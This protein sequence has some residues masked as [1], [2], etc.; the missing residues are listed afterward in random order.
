MTGNVY[1][2]LGAWGPVFE[3]GPD[4]EEGKRDLEDIVVDP[5]A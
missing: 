3:N 2:I 5:P 4:H 1:G